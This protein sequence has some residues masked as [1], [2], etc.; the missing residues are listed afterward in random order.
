M[1]KL[2]EENTETAIMSLDITK[3]S[4]ELCFVEQL[5]HRSRDSKPA[6]TNSELIFTSLSSRVTK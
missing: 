2:V 3:R 1:N 6:I 4:F 5:C